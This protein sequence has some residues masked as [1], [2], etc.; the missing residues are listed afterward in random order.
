[1]TFVRSVKYLGVGA[2]Q[3]TEITLVK[4]LIYSPSKVIGKENTPLMKSMR[5][6]NYSRA[7]PLITQFFGFVE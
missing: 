4:N 6:R 3:K 7:I 5:F 2:N 1:M